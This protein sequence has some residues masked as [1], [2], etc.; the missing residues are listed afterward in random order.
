MKL[1]HAAELAVRGALVLAEEYGQGPVPLAEICRRRELPREYLT[2]IFSSLS[3]AG[4]LKPIR[5]KGGGFVLAREPSEITLLEVIEA[6]EGPIILNFCQH[7]P[8]QC[9]RD[10]CPV[11][12]VWSD[13]QDHIRTTLGSRTLGDFVA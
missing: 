13:L 1:T 2:K 11:R 5:G 8:P 12:P 7:D 6:V 10:D 9:E 4:L 3:R